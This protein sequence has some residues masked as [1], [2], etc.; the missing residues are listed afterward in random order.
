MRGKRKNE[1]S[2][3]YLE[4]DKQGYFVFN[5]KFSEPIL[6]IL[7]KRYDRVQKGDI[8]AGTFND[9]GFF[10]IQ[11]IDDKKYLININN[12]IYKELDDVDNIIYKNYFFDDKGL[13]FY[14]VKG[15]SFYQFKLDL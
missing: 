12:E 10:A 7:P 6:P 2:L 1:N 3:F 13:I 14:G 5:G 8:I 4:Y 9:Y 11:K 15:Y